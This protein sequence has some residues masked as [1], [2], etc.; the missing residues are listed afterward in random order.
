MH[1][2]IRISAAALGLLAALPAAAEMSRETDPRIIVPAERA[3]IIERDG[4]ATE[5]VVGGNYAMP[6]K[7]RFQVGLMATNRLT[8]TNDS[9][10]LAQ[11]CGGSLIAP[12]WVLT[13]AH[14][15]TDGS[16]VAYPASNNTVLPDTTSLLEGTRYEVEEVIVHESWN[17]ATIDYDIALLKLKT[18]LNLPVVQLEDGSADT[19]TGAGTGIG[20]GLMADGSS[21]VHL[22]EGQIDLVPSETCNEGLKGYARADFSRWL[23]D[24]ASFHPLREGALTQALDVISE[25]LSDRLTERMMC[26]GTKSGQIGACHGDSGGPLVID[27]QEGPLQLGVVSFGG[28]PAGSRMY[29]GF[30]DVYGI[31]ARV[32][33]FRDWI[34]EKSGV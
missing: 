30:E 9:Q 29:C 8:D 14:C 13:A 16:G 15:V 31:Y 1:N 3:A 11:F 24:L 32:S 23:G 21:P 22:L 28:G 18:P 12:Q 5:R 26:A 27:T 33:Y 20:W 2:V 17:P 7:W 19:D 4:G 10:Y 6:G 25:G 34:R